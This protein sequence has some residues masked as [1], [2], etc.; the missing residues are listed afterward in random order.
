MTGTSTEKSSASQ[1]LDDL[2]FELHDREGGDWTDHQKS[3]LS[4]ELQTFASTCLFPHNCL[5]SNFSTAFDD[6]IIA[7]ARSS[8]TRMIVGFT[9]AVFLKGFNDKSVPFV[10]HTGLT[11][12]SENL[13]RQNLTIFL[14]YHIFVRLCS[15][16]PEGFWLSNLAGITSS[17]GSISR[18]GTNVYPSP[19]FPTPS[20]MHRLIAKTI[21]LCHW[22]KMLVSSSAVFD[23]ERFVFLGSNKPG[24]CFYKDRDDVRYA[25]RQSTINEFYRKLLRKDGGDEVLQIAF[26]NSEQ[27][28][29]SRYESRFEKLEDRKSKL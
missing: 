29:D 3:Q 8:T 14:F 7:I 28:F 11:C 6:K 20:S 25:D 12:V 19:S 9:S 4:Q 22:S 27:L 18:Y 23:S 1:V 17:L 26:V 13:R 21:D 2:D 10:L 16:Y 5:S 24:S 15:S